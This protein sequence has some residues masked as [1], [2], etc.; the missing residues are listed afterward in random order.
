ML[1]VQPSGAHYHRALQARSVSRSVW[2][3][4][5]RTS[6]PGQIV[7]VYDRASTL[8]FP[9]GNLVSLVS[10]E[11]G[12]GP[13]NIVMAPRSFPPEADI[14]RALAAFQPGQEVHLE[15]RWLEVGEFAVSLDG[16]VTWEPCPDWERLRTRRETIT[17]H[18]AH[19]KALALRLARED[20]LLVLVGADPGRDR[21]ASASYRPADSFHF[22]ESLQSV[23]LEAALI[24]RAG[25]EG[26]STQLQVGAEQLAGL[27]GGLTPAGDD[28]LSG[29]MLWTWLA[30]P[31]PEPCCRV[32]LEAAASRT[33]TF[34]AALLRAAAAGECSTSWHRLLAILE[35]GEV[36]H[37]AAT[38]EEV[39]SYGHTSGADTL[40]GFLWPCIGLTTTG[41]KSLTL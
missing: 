25:W 26:D 5:D 33:T 24:L 39:L 21:P 1:G 32:M 34:S 13:L 22:E 3:T 8:A 12:D 19:L 35:R 31:D 29:V 30:H 6:F 17:G 20:S 38:V 14:P 40:A 4:L 28:F 15:D 37:L 36:Q 10:P 41:P 7:A 23:A 27:G 18:L 2:E 9:D 11:I 16:A